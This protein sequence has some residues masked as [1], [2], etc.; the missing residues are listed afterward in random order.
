MN[1]VVHLQKSG[2]GFT[3][4]M[5]MKLVDKIAIG[6]GLLYCYFSKR[7][8]AYIISNLKH[9][10]TDDIISQEQM[11]CLLKRTFTNFALTMTDFFRLAFMSKQDIINSSECIG[12]ENITQALAQG[13]GCVLITLHLGNWDYAGAY[14]AA[15]GVPMTA[16]VEETDAEMLALYTKH[17][18]STGMRTYPVN[19]AGHA[20]LDIIKNNRVL[21]V[22][23]DRDVVKNGIPINFFS[24]NRMIPKGLAEIIIKKKIP[25]I[26]AY[27]VL[28]AS[29]RR[30]RYLGVIEEP[31]VYDG[32]AGSF[33]RLMVDKF[34]GFIKQY[35]EQW[36]VFHPEWIE[37]KADA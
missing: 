2:V 31:F 7:K 13:S 5:P 33:N 21:A 25:V 17:R 9:I 20:F 6:A 29:N 18:E 36:F 30:A 15:R 19:R 23:A 26:F 11:N 22:L 24:G 4:L 34:E 27:M 12:Y 10:F 8:R 16:L 28:S 1:P 14:L 32:E 3:R 37:E 35:P